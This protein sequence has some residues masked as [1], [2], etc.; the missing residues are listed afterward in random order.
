MITVTVLVEFTPVPMSL[1]IER[2]AIGRHWCNTGAVVSMI[3]FSAWQPNWD[4]VADTIAVLLLHQHP[5][6]F[7]V[8][9][10]V[11]ALPFGHCHMPI[12][13]GG[14]TPQMDCITMLCKGTVLCLWRYKRDKLQKGWVF[15]DGTWKVYFLTGRMGEVLDDRKVDV[16]SV[17]E[18]RWMGCGCRFLVPWA[19]GISCFGVAVRRSWEYGSICSW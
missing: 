19:K 18:M 12:Q 8:A 3:I 4:S 6:T 5:E 13:T 15:R 17:Q 16:A 14:E 2:L 10:K 1:Y 9:I 11:W 7:Q